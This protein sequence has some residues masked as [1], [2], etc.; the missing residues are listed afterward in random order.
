MNY[1]HRRHRSQLH[2]RVTWRKGIYA[3]KGLEAIKRRLRLKALALERCCW[4][5][6]ATPPA[7]DQQNPERMRTKIAKARTKGHLQAVERLAHKSSPRTITDSEASLGRLARRRDP[8]E[9]YRHPATS[10]A[11]RGSPPNRAATSPR[12]PVVEPMRALPGSPVDGVSPLKQKL[13][14]DAGPTGQPLGNDLHPA[15]D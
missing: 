15:S 3:G 6:P 12:H 7:L 9:E 10:S 13:L 8:Q 14:E 4:P 5:L 2:L 1:K 11:P